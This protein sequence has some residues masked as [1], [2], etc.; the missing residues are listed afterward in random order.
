LSLL[1]KHTFTDPNFFIKERRLFDSFFYV[2]WS[3][4][5]QPAY[6]FYNIRQ[7]FSVIDL[8]DKI[9]DEVNSW[10]AVRV[11]VRKEVWLSCNKSKIYTRC[12]VRFT[13]NKYSDTLCY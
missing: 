7:Q 12:F 3:L 5:K 4:W 13:P 1:P 9:V 10:V 2:Y 8:A 6:V 11:V